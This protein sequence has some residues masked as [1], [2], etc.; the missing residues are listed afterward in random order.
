MTWTAARGCGQVPGKQVSH[1]AQARRAPPMP[2]DA[3]AL[4]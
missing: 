3:R 4:L 2:Y 1:Q